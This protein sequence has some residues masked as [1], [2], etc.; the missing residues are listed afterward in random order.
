MAE[1]L[2]KIENDLHKYEFGLENGLITEKEY[3]ELTATLSFE[4]KQLAEQL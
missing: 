2:R 3:A 4:L 1:K